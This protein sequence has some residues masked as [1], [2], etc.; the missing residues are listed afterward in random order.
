MTDCNILD[1]GCNVQNFANWLYS[2]FSP[3]LDPIL[4]LISSLLNLIFTIWGLLVGLFTALFALGTTILSFVGMFT[5][6][7]NSD[8]IMLS[9]ITLIIGYISIIIFLRVWNIIAELEIAGFKLPKI[10]V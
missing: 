2:F 8:P 6:L 9:I 4:N 10:K 7:W 3:Y 1:V 5:T